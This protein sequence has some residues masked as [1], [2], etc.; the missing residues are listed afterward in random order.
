[1][2]A[3]RHIPRE[4]V[5]LATKCGILSVGPYNMEVRGTPQYVRSCCEASLNRLGV[6]YIDLYYQHRIDTSVP[7]DETVSHLLSASFQWAYLFL[8]TKCNLQLFVMK[9]S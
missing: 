3:L 5:Q 7:I 8:G 9:E 2:Q 1:M 6:D 4:K